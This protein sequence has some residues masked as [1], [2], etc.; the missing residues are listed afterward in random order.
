MPDLVL[1]YVLDGRHPGYNFTTPTD[2]FD[3]ATLKTIWRNAMPRGQGWGEYVGARSLKCFALAG[4]W[5]VAVSEVFVTNQ[6]DEGGR[7]GIR[8]AEITVM[9]AE[10]FQA[11]L[12]V[13]LAMLPEP[14]REAAG[15]KLNWWRWRRILDRASKGRGKNK[16]QVVL[17]HPYTSEAGWQMAEAV[18]LQLATARRLRSVKGW[19]RLNSLTTL[20][21]GH[22][23]ESRLVA[24]PLNKARDISDVPVV[25]LSN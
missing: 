20:A 5:R 4:G 21:L 23:D 15:E 22:R 25:N 9:P 10:K 3:D 19:E 8:R 2:R 1:E 13:R 7:R 17:A 24:I 6:V 12:Q 14:V 11:Y 16:N 18:L